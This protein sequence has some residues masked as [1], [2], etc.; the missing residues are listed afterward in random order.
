MKTRKNHRYS[1]RSGSGRKTVLKK[2]LDLGKTVSKKTIDL[3]KTVSEEWAKDS[4]KKMGENI[5][6]KTPK[7]KFNTPSRGLNKTIRMNMY[8]KKHSYR[9]PD[10]TNSLVLEELKSDDTFQ[11]PSV[12]RKL[13]FSVSTHKKPKKGKQQIPGA[14]ISHIAN[15]T[16]VKKNPNDLF[17]SSSM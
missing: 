1:Q 4:I 12:N 16:E 10:K 8:S 14:Y 7:I 11:S 6:F 2:T 13:R 9:S 3:G 5:L 17:A 15:I